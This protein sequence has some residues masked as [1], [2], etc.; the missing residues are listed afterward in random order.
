[1][2]SWSGIRKKLEKEYTYQGK[3]LNSLI[4]DYLDSREKIDGEP[5]LLKPLLALLHIYGYHNINTNSNDF[6]LTLEDMSK[7]NT[8]LFFEEN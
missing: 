2:A 4:I 8:K 5:E 3:N 1:M 7:E 6:F